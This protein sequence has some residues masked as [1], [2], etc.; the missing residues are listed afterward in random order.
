MKEEVK[1]EIDLEKSPWTKKELEALQIIV[2]YYKSGQDNKTL[3]SII[4]PEYFPQIVRKCTNDALQSII[5]PEYLGQLF[6]KSNTEDHLTVMY[7]VQGLM[8]TVYGVYT[9][10]L[11]TTLIGLF[12]AAADSK[13]ANVVGRLET[14][15]FCLGSTSTLAIEPV[16]FC[17]SLIRDGVYSFVQSIGALTAGFPE[18]ENSL[19]DVAEDISAK[20]NN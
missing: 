1:Q 14:V 17:R 15:Q 16:L 11:M 3:E 2:N 12:I 10:Q 13:A 18:N 20:K 4:N 5:N 19:E 7:F 9:G 6:R 8:T